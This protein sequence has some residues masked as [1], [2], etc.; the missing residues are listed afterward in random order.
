MSRPTPLK[1]NTTRSSC[2]LPGG[3]DCFSL[4]LP[5]P[6]GNKQSLLVKLKRG[7][8]DPLLMCRFG[9]EPPRVPRRAR[10]IADV[11]D[12]QS[13]D[14]DAAEHVLR[15][16]LPAGGGPAVL[17]VHNYAAHRREPCHYTI[18]VMI[19]LSADPAASPRREPLVS[20][21][22]QP[23]E[24][25]GEGKVAA[26]GSA[27]GGVGTPSRQQAAAAAATAAAAAVA[28]AA[29]SSAAAAAAGGGATG[30]AL[31][32]A[33]SAADLRLELQLRGR[34]LE[35]LQARTVISADLACS[36]L[37]LPLICRRRRRGGTRRRR[38]AR[39]AR[40]A[41]RSS[42]RR[43]RSTTGGAA[44]RCPPPS[45]AGRGGWKAR[46]AGARSTTRRCCAPS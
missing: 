16:A 43:P 11:W 31:G 19:G 45:R 30:F 21:H 5:P 33:V 2:T 42:R 34:E 1:L 29:S 39:R 36:E 4:T 40:A 35:L 8:G 13:F 17:G 6:D 3:T 22:L 15:V 10:V 41:R 14:S 27:A 32:H 12:Q 37:D 23:T 28:A 26:A 20:D 7:G 38:S 46:R 9:T 18:S 25:H 24:H 44:A